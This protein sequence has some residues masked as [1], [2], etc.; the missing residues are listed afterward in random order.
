MH[1]TSGISSLAMCNSVGSSYLNTL[2]SIGE[3]LGEYVDFL[4][5]RNEY[6]DILKSKVGDIQNLNLQNKAGC[7]VAGT[8]LH[9]FVGD[10]IP[11]I[12]IDVGVSTFI[13]SVANSY[14]INLLYEF[15][16]TI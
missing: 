10:S 6:L 15:I 14:G 7:I 3:D 9:Y 4:K 11:W 2:M 12:H 16:K 1:I 13:D 5:I 8:F